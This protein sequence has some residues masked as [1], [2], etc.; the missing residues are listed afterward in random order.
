MDN[1]P[2]IVLLQFISRLMFLKFQSELE[3]HMS[4]HYT[5]RVPKFGRFWRFS[6]IFSI[7]YEQI[8]MKFG[9]KTGESFI[10]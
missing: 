4:E 1:R 5:G 9:M 6:S 10:Y 8:C 3:L 2:V 7:I